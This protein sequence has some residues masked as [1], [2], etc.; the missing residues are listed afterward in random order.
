MRHVIAFGMITLSLNNP[1]PAVAATPDEF[2]SPQWIRVMDDDGAFAEQWVMISSPAAGV[3]K[4]LTLD[5][6]PGE[7]RDAAVEYLIVAPPYDSGIKQHIKD[8]E[9]HWANLVIKVNGE[10]ILDQPAGKHIMPGTHRVK[11]SPAFLRNG[12]NTI[13]IF[14]KPIPEEL[15]GRLIHGYIYLAVRREP[16]ACGKRAKDDKVGIRLLLNIGY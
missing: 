3:R 11:F 13:G 12:E 15:R 9:Y 14:W 7:A 10:V 16:K 6:D 5:F 2:N 4:I 8:T 1:C